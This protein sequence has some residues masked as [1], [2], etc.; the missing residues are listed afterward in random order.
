[1]MAS[2]SGLNFNFHNLTTGL[3]AAK[4]PI[5][6]LMCLYPLVAFFVMML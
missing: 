6:G 1:M 4:D 5:Y 3:F 2:L